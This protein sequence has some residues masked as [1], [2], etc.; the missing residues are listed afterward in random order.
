MLRYRTQGILAVG[1]GLFAGGCFGDPEIR[2][3]LRPEGPPQILVGMGQS[4][5][6][7]EE[8]A[9]FCRYVGGVKD[10]KAPGFV[11]DAILGSQTVCPDEAG[12]FAATDVD[13]RGYAVRIM[14]DELLDGDSVE[15]LDCDEEGVCVGSLA[16]TQPVTFNCGATAVDYDGYYVPNGNNTTFPLGPSLVVY[17]TSFDVATGTACTI[18]MGDAIRDKSGEGVEA[19]EADVDFNI[20]ALTLLATDP[21]DEEAVDDRAVLDPDGFVDFV[22]NAS[23]DAASISAADWEVVNTD[24]NAV[25]TGVVAEVAD[26]NGMGLGD[27]VEIYHDTMAG[28]PAG[29]YTARIKAGATFTEVNGGTITI[30]EA[31]EVRFVVE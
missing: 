31:V 29:H 8:Y 23:I 20:A 16:T 19:A 12:D 9:F 18:S 10:E 13:P 2:T 17:P 21:E 26:Y 7:A 6:T 28:F 27:A 24:T 14:F 4:L 1:L 11:I 25:I 22:F 30:D 15:T 3:S 5:V